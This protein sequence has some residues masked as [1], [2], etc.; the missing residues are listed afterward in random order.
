[1]GNLHEIKEFEVLGGTTIDEAV[2]EARALAKAEDCII[3]FKFN[4]AIMTIYKFSDIQQ[5]IDDYY[6]QLRKNAD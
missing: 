2:L 6:I 5:Q 4:S 1:M 3:R